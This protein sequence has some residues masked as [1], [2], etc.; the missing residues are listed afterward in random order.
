MRL[1]CCMKTIG[2]LLAH[3]AEIQTDKLVFQF[4]EHG[5]LETERRTFGQLFENSKKIAA[6]MDMEV[7]PESGENKIAILAFPVGIEFIETFFACILAGYTAIPMYPPELIGIEKS[8][9]IML[10][11]SKDSQSKLVLCSS[12]LS[13][14]WSCEKT[15]NIQFIN[16]DPAKVE[17][18]PVFNPERQAATAVIQYTSGSTGLPR[19]VILSHENI[20][21]NELMINKAFRSHEE[22][23]LVSWL[24]VGHDMGLIGTVLQPIHTGFSTYFMSPFSFISKPIRWLQAIHKYRATDSG[25]PNFAFDLCVKKISTEDCQKKNL[26]LSSWTLAYNGAE[27]VRPGTLDNFVN[28]FSPFGFSRTTFFPCYGLAEA[29]LF[30]CGKGGFDQQ[31][32]VLH[33]SAQELS[34]D[35]AVIVEAGSKGSLPLTGCGIPSED[36]GLI[37]K[38]MDSQNE[39]ELPEMKIGEIRIKGPSVAQ[40]YFNRSQEDNAAFDSKDGFLRTGDLGFLCDGELFVTGRIKDLIKINGLNRYPQDIEYVAERAHQNIRGGGCAAFSVDNG[41]TED[42]ILFAEIKDTKNFEEIAEAVKQKLSAELGLALS[43]LVLI[44]SGHI[45][46]T[47]SGKPQRQECKR[48]YLLKDYDSYWIGF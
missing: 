45:P 20:L 27:P 3:R 5:E 25:A 36:S 21:S 11:I 4:L 40:G 18:V 6:Q 1:S 33:I 32:R 12:F 13:E 42:L 29:T 22:T 48:R 28:K 30:V 47:S 19:G 39:T 2:E 46:K 17:E 41:V 15:K 9:E 10:L 43:V 31:Y 34:K 26:D 8:L 16:P 37:V 7:R 14:K 24:P 23:I 35:L 44:P 38:I